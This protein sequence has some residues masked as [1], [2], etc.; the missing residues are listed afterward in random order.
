MKVKVLVFDAYGTLFNVNSLDQLLEEYYGDQA[1]QLSALWRAK[2]LQYTWLRTLMERYKPF[3]EITMDTLEFACTQLKLPLNKKIKAHLAQEYDQLAA[4]AEVKSV[5]TELQSKYQ[6]AILSNADPQMLNNAVDHNQLTSYFS[7]ILSA[8]S[9]SK[10]KPRC[11]VYQLAVDA[12][13]RKA[14]N[15]LFAS[16]N[17]WD[18]AGAKSFG[19]QVAW[20][21][22]STI[23]LDNLGFEPDYI[24]ENL[25][26]L[27]DL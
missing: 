23:G 6:L 5:L 19:L 13:N 7:W 25:S 4:F 24:I 14:K 26:E 11:E 22:R 18:V 21:K 20:L 8:H 9:I 27:L 3:S 16:S 1:T 17:T 12:T 10:F 15:I 2:Q